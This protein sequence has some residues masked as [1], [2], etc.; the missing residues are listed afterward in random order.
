M[1]LPYWNN[2]LA[3]YFTL[4]PLRCIF[5]FARA[6]NTLLNVTTSGLIVEKASLRYFFKILVS[7]DSARTAESGFEL[8]AHELITVLYDRR[9]G[10]T[11]S[12]PPFFFGYSGQLSSLHN[13]SSALLEASG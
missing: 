1:R 4:L 10:L 3:K 11:T 9:F 12:T 6:F 5:D 13:I 2:G 8:F 7:K